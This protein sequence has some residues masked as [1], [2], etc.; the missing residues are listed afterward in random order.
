MTHDIRV[1]HVTRVEGHGNIVLNTRNGK[2]EDLKLEIVESP[3]FF[4]MMLKDRKYDEAPH[5]TSRICGICAVGHTT[6]S[7]KAVEAALDMVPSEQT[8]LLRK[9]VLNAEIIQSHVLHYYFLVAPDFF[10]A[11]SVIP[12]AASHPDVVKRALRMKKTANDICE[13][14]VGR[15]VH[16]IAMTVNGFTKLPSMK[17]LDKVRHLLEATIPDLEETVKLFQSLKMPD[18]K[19]KTEY[20]SLSGDDEYAFYDG[21]LISTEAK[22]LE[23]NRYK[24]VIIEHVVDHSTAKHVKSDQASIMVGALARLNNNLEQLCPE[25]KAVADEFG[26][27]VPCY[28]PFMNNAAQVVETVHCIYESLRLIDIIVSWG[29]R[30]EKPEF[31]IRAGKGVGAV[32]VPRGTLYHEYEMDDKG[33][34]KEANCI[35]PTT[36]NLLNI[37]KDMEAFVPDI[38]NLPKEEIRLKLEMLVRAY[39]PC[40]SCSTHFLEVTF[41]D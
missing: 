5:I 13:I 12:L 17:E 24:D 2:I 23:T 4:E 11:G 34:I 14:L 10:G 3:R 35:I 29:I 20:F 32:E 28:N 36:Q 8:I 33:I 9:I 25:A 40:I 21:R 37:E 38:I 22:S 15:H 7:L 41:I 27:K 18:F 1:N 26:L 31:K 16:P 39:D 30:E 6:A 19:R